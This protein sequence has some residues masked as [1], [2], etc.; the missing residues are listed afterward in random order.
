M[1][2]GVRRNLKTTAIIYQVSQKPQLE[3][4]SRGKFWL[5][6]PC[7][8]MVGSTHYTAAGYGYFPKFME[9]R[10]GNYNGPRARLKMPI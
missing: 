10:V 4:K 8:S 9:R 5:K 2:P 3:L 6:L 1:Q 7:Q